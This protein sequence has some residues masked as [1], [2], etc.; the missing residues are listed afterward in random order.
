MQSS[1][2]EA[3]W[4]MCCENGQVRVPGDTLVERYVDS[5]AHGD[6]LQPIQVQLKY[7]VGTVM[8]LYYTHVCPNAQFVVYGASAV[9]YPYSVLGEPPMTN[10]AEHITKVPPNRKNY[11]LDNGYH[12]HHISHHLRYRVLSKHVCESCTPLD[13]FALF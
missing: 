5:L 8:G 10:A 13:V 4:G 1:V 2:D 6:T 9:N 7:M 11:L 12:M 3:A